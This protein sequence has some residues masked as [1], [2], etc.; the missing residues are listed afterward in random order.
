MTGPQRLRPP[1]PPTS[2]MQLLMMRLGPGL[3]SSGSILAEH[4]QELHVYSDVR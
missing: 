1:S 3:G 2:Y 4:V